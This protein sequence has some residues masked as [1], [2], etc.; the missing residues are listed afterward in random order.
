MTVDTNLAGLIHF[1]DVWYSRD[2]KNWTELKSNVI[3]KNRHE[4]S[5]LV[6]KDKIWVAGGYAETLNSEVWTLEIPEGWFEDE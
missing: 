3:W 1:G 5:T 2:G 6:F 4:H